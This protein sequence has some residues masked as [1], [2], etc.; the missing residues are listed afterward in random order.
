M[1]HYN[2]LGIVPRRSDEKQ[3]TRAILS[4]RLF[5]HVVDDLA[6]LV[7]RAKHDD[8]RVSINPHIVAWWPV[9][10]VAGADCLLVAGCVGRGELTT[11]YEAPMRT[12]T[13]VSFQPLE[14]RGGIHA[15]GKGEVLAADLAVSTRIAEIRALTDNGAWDCHFDIDLF[16]CNPHVLILCH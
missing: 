11:Q 7:L 13:E 8:L 4:L 16:L 9:E 15:C 6:M 10:Q 14:E 2:V 3:L 5:N 12:L 1:N